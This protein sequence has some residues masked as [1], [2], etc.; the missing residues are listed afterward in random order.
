MNLLTS[1]K[2]VTTALIL[3]VLLNVTLLGVLWWQNMVKSESRHVTITRQINRQLSLSGP[4]ALSESQSASFQKLRK[5]HFE[6]VLPEIEAINGQKKIIIEE[7]LKDQPDI[8]KIE[9]LASSIGIHQATM[10]RELAAHF[11]ELSKICTP[12]QRDSL[13]TI[14]EHISTH[15]LPNRR[16]ERW[17]FL[18]PFRESIT[19]KETQSR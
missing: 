9:A 2:F 8:K 12:E 15:N 3:L 18:P 13:K 5:E 16:G 19:V 17:G 14:L 4:L 11:H 1:K 10:E 7:S 6:K